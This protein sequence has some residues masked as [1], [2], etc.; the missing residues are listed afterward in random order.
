MEHLSGQVRQK[1]ENLIQ[2][3]LGSLFNGK[4]LPPSVI[5]KALNAHSLTRDCISWR[6]HGGPHSIP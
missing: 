2:G 5:Q 1:Q 4:L 6:R 3:A